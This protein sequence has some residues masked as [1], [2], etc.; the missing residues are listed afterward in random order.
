LT[1]DLY[2]KIIEHEIFFGK[3]IVLNSIDSYDNGVE[4]VLVA[5]GLLSPIAQVLLPP[6][7]IIIVL[8]LILLLLLFITVLILRPPLF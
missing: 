6:L 1:D 5:L 7:L 3:K 4:S 8:L 2:C